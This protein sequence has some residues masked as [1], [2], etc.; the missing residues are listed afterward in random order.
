MKN[1]ADMETVMGLVDSKVEKDFIDQLI[2]RINKI[3]EMAAAKIVQAQKPEEESEKE[4][5][6]EKEAGSPDFIVKKK[7]KKGDVDSEEEAK[8]EEMRK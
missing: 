4:V 5:V 7:K 6:D 8:A 2:E 1:K 3:E